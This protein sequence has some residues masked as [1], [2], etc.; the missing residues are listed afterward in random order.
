MFVVKDPDSGL[1]I[2]TYWTTGCQLK[3]LDRAIEF[4]TQE[5][6]QQ[7]ADKYKMIVEPAPLV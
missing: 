3:E 1:Y 2:G 6:A 4:L 5:E 7:V